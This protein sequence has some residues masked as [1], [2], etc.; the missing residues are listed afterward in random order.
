VTKPQI[1]KPR[2]LLWDIETTHNIVASFR[3]WGEDYIPHQNLIQERYIVC[4]A[5]KE[6]GERKVHT[7]STLDNAKRFSANPHDDYHVVKT[8]HDTLSEADVVVAH[9]GDAYDMK[10]F[11]G[12]AI[13]HGLP[14]LPPIVQI[15]TKKVAKGQFLFN[16]NRLDYLGQYL[17]V[18]RKIET[19]PG[20]WMKILTGTDS[21]RR[22]A[23]GEMVTYNQQ[24]V[25]LLEDVFKKLMPYVQTQ[26]N[27]A[28]FSYSETL[29]CPKPWCGSEN[30]QSR[31]T[32]KAQV[33]EYKRYQ[34]QKCGGWFKLRKAE[35]GPK[36]ATQTL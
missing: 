24:D 36:V 20:L 30:V 4:A 34:C 23:I 14:P 2:I 33:K 7:V 27:S 28:M 19:T 8:L 9:H 32:H 11:K 5:W 17:G 12:R 35:P 21:V 18:G 31:G 16:S 6:L 26:L 1:R 29:A 3:L 25:L 22:K 15:D 10:F 13:A